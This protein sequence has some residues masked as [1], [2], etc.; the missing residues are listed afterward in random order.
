[1]PRPKR[2]VEPLTSEKVKAIHSKLQEDRTGNTLTQD[3]RNLEVTH[4]EAAFL[5]SAIA[6][7]FISH[8]YLGQ[9]TREDKDHKR[10]LHPYRS[11]GSA[12]TYQVEALLKIRFISQAKRKQSEQKSEVEPEAA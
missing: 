9:L 5:L 3:E 6:G 4:E 11:V 12:Y 1:M 2:I 8:R 7:R 10:R